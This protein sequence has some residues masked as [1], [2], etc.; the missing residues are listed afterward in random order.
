MWSGAQ[1]TPLFANDAKAGKIYVVEAG[2]LIT[3]AATGCVDDRARARHQ[4]AGHDARQLDRADRPGVIAVRAV[5]SPQHL[6]CADDR[7]GG[8]RTRR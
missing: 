7:R 1:F 3:T 2:G 5:V 8:V 6:G 4:F